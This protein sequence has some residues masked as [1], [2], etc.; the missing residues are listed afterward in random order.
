MRKTQSKNCGRSRQNAEG[1]IHLL[2][3]MDF[4]QRNLR[5]RG[6][7]SA[8]SRSS[9]GLN[10]LKTRPLSLLDK[11][12]QTA[13]PSPETSLWEGGAEG[14]GGRGIQG[15]GGGGGGAETTSLGGR[16]TE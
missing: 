6:G 10:H 13:F 3:E 4:Q 12:V 5:E 16:P 15:R 1:D 9:S 2:Q 11:L 7:T 14:R 8:E